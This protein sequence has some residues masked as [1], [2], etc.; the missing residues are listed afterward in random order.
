MGGLVADP[1]HLPQDF[2]LPHL[3]VFEIRA[4]C[5]EPFNL[6]RRAFNRS[7]SFF[8]DFILVSSVLSSEYSL[9]MLPACLFSVSSLGLVSILLN[10]VDDFVASPAMFFEEAEKSLG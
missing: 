3:P 9:Y 5:P 6:M 10:F 8:D 1:I 2:F 4:T 7:V